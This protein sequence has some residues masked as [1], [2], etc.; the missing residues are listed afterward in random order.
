VAPLKCGGVAGRIYLKFTDTILSFSLNIKNPARENSRSAT[1][2]KQQSLP[3]VICVA[4]G[5]LHAP[6][7]IQGAVKK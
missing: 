5:R 1:S 4:L 3:L 7:I 6:K 2:N